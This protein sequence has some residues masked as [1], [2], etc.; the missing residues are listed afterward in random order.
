VLVLV[1]TRTLAPLQ[2]LAL[3]QSRVPLGFECTGD[4]PVRRIDR[5]ITVR[6]SWPVILRV[7]EL[8]A[9]LL[10]RRSAIAL[11]RVQG[12]HRQ[13]H[14]GWCHGAQKER[15]HRRIDPCG[16][17]ALTRRASLIVVGL[18][19]GIGGGS[20]FSGRIVLDAHC[21]SAAATEDNALE[22]GC[23]CT[24]GTTAVRTV[25][26]GAEEGLVRAKLLP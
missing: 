12:T 15:R 11:Q 8:Q 22:Q 13:V 14:L 16:A 23:P 4:E 9:P 5:L 10:T 26:V 21:A 2:C 3:L 18:I 25:P 19:T 24:G 7:V 20:L 17:H 1:L 6:R